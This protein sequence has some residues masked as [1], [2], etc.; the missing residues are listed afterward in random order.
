[1]EMMCRWVDGYFAPLPEAQEE[2]Q[3][4]KSGKDY[5]IKASQPRNY[6]HHKKFMALCKVA[7]ENSEYESAM[8]FD[9]FRR[10]ITRRAGYYEEFK[11]LKGDM[12]YRAKSISFAKMDQ[13]EF[14]DLYSRSIDVVLR[15]CIRGA[16][17]EEVRVM[18]EEYLRFL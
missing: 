16:T 10:E 2:A 8:T 15:Y 3:K 13:T 1:M 7:H 12:E 18:V 9:N 6:E 14:E 11:T 5:R 4:L 17:D